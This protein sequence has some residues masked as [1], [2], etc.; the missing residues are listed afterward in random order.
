MELTVDFGW[1]DEQQQ[2][3]EA[4]LRFARAELATDLAKWESAGSFPPQAWRRCAEFG[5]QGMPV[6]Q[7]FGGQGADLVTTAMVF[8]TLGHGSADN[9]LLFSLGAHLWSC[10]LPIL[11][12]GTDE[13]RSRYL[14]GLCDGSL[15]GVQA[16]T[17]HGSGSDALAVS[18]TATP[19]PDGYV[20]DGAKTYITNAPVAGVFLVLAALADR[21][22]PSRLC[23]FVVDRDSP[24][25][26]VGEPVDKLGLKTSPMAEVYLSG[27]RV[28]AS[29]LLGEPGAGMTVFTTTIE[30]ERGFIMA[31][32]LGTM[33]RQL[34]EAVTHAKGHRRFGRPIGQNQSVANRIVDMRVRLDSA[35]L[36]VYQLAWLKD[37]GKRT[38]M[39]SAIVKL[40]V[41][42]S[43][44]DNSMAAMELFG[45]AGYMAGAPQERDVRDALAS[46]FYS[47][48]ADIQRTI[49]AR[50]LGL[51]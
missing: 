51:P 44:V 19:V 50:L 11:R 16:V 3:R 49:V 18:T 14:P 4:T 28:P 36:L 41:S 38:P 5:I 2:L 13:Q 23:A 20:L 34:D 47:G 26:T 25:L 40:A 39:E 15:I 48:T 7:R 8:E 33:A 43:L 1:T 17:E 45:A 10:A 9:G 46:R 35:R 30:W 42:E 12:F 24:G 21:T 27:C 37:Q 31:S 29:A 22:G 32:A 6:P